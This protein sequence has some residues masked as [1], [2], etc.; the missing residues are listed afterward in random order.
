LSGN[1]RRDGEHKRRYQKGHAATSRGTDCQRLFELA[2]RY[3]DPTFLL[4]LT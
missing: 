3:A 1:R 4:Q 2:S